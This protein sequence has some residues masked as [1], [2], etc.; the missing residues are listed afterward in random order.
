MKLFTLIL[1]LLSLNAFA[2]EKCFDIR[3][4]GEVCVTYNGT[5]IDKEVQVSIYKGDVLKETL[6]AKGSAYSSGGSYCGG[7]EHDCW[8]IPG[9]FQIHAESAKY[10][11]FL[12]LSRWMTINSCVRCSNS[13]VTVVD[14]KRQYFKVE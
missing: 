10:S 3:S 14:D 13:S 2:E 4:Y 11:V 7:K 5:A 9:G 1:I 8:T 12:N 6:T